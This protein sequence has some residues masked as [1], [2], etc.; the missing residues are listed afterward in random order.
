VSSDRFCHRRKSGFLR[1]WE[2]ERK[3][4]LLLSDT[5]I[6]RMC[7]SVLT[8]DFV[9]IFFH[10]RR[11]VYTEEFRE[12]TW[13]GMCLIVRAKGNHEQLFLL[14]KTREIWSWP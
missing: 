13:D 3:K 9:A 8:A 11:E 2:K 6:P 14:R 10:K 4:I 7:L 5:P 12:I 1:R